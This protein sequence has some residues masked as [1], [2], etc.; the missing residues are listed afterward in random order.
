MKPSRAGA[1]ARDVSS[2]RSNRIRCCDLSFT[3]TSCWCHSGLDLLQVAREQGDLLGQPTVGT[4]EHAE[5]GGNDGGGSGGTQGEDPAQKGR[6][7]SIYYKA[8]P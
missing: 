8:Y 3:L 1:S 7:E 5:Q 2:T 4:S 6:G